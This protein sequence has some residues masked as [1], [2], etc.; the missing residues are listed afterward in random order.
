MTEHEIRQMIM[1]S[2]NRIEERQNTQGELLAKLYEHTAHLVTKEACA[3]KHSVHTREEQKNQEQPHNPH[4]PNSAIS[5]V[6]SGKRIYIPLA[7]FA[8][9]AAAAAVIIQALR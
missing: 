7:L 1:K 9:L 2:L 3:L 5:I 6:S 4:D 8:A